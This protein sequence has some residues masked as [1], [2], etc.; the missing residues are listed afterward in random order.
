[1]GSMLTDSQ[2]YFRAMTGAVILKQRNFV[3]RFRL[4]GL[5]ANAL[6]QRIED[7]RGENGG[8]AGVKAG[9]KLTVVVE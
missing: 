2:N 4:I 7:V 9:G 6:K 1:M 5:F 3:S 8:R